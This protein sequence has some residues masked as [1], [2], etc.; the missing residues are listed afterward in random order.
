ML[1]I[2]LNVRP[3]RR[4]ERGLTLV[5]LMVSI[6][7]GMF[8]VAGAVSVFVTHLSNSRK[9]LLEA[10]VEQDLR[11]AADLISR[12]VR[13]AGY[14][15]NA[16]RGTVATGSSSTTTANDYAVMTWDTSTSQVTYRY[17]RDV[18]ENNTTDT[19]EQFGFKLNSTDH[20]LEMQTANGTWQKITDPDSIS[21]DSFTIDP[22]SSPVDVSVAC[23]RTCC[24]SAMVTAGTCTTV[25]ITP[26][27]STCPKITLR[28][29]DFTIVAHATTDSKVA[30]S[31]K[32]R[33]R[34]R[35]DA[36]SGVCPP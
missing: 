32:T 14:W 33:T 22:T 19:N 28:Q 15:Q 16:I 4:R 9:M 7:V 24:D 5:E 23:A 21:I 3:G 10:R 6:A 11:A 18:T 29:I 17:S 13:R 20:T 12:D 26:N 27:T 35:N 1:K 25:N 30:R 8:L 2:A 36:L 34:V 31:L